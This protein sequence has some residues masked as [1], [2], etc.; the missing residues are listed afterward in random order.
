MKRMNLMWLAALVASAF[1]VKGASAANAAAS[2]AL[3]QT[4]PEIEAMMVG[5]KAVTLAGLAG[6]PVVLQFGSITEPVF[7][8]RVPN[9]EK[10][11]AKY[12]D[13]V[14]FL[15]IYT[16]E[17]HAADTEAAIEVNALSGFAVSKPVNQEERI[18]MAGQAIEQLGIKRQQ[19]AVD[20]WSNT[21]SL[22]YG[23]YPNM[24]FVIDSKGNLQAGYPWMDPAMVKGAV[25]ALLAGK[26]VPAEFRGRTQ[27]ASPGQVDFMA[28]AKDMDGGKAGAGL[29]TVLDNLKLTEKQKEAVYP[30]LTEYL[31]MARNFREKRGAAAPGAPGAVKA[32]SGEMAEK[33]ESPEEFKKS[34]DA[35]R[36]AAQ[37]LKEAVKKNLSE[38]D[39]KQVMDVLDRGPAR[40]MFA[41]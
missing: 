15:T 5:G 8:M 7:R 40:R 4:A 31:A 24:T 38:A 11:A 25:D 22:R 20:A 16:H 1:A 27:A 41:D 18:K 17:S 33:A 36:A 6:K 37:N 39:A 10:M 9:V 29:S 12:G 2:L 26:A 21:S 28:A 3:G 34:V 14:M 30:A 19:V 35:L 13:K 23:D 32:A